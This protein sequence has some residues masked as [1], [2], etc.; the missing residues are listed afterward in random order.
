VKSRV[1]SHVSMK[2][3]K[4][5]KSK[6]QPGGRAKKKAA[7]GARS[8]K[9]RGEAKRRGGAAGGATPRGMGGNANRKPGAARQ[10]VGVEKTVTAEDRPGASAGSAREP[11]DRGAPPA[12]PTP[13]ATFNI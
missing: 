8:D 4:K 6:S 3:K 7:A 13:I 9:K 5:A 10:E 11:E 1:V 2:A 12:L